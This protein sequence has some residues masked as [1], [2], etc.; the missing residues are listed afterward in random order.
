MTKQTKY[1]IKKLEKSIE[2]AKKFISKTENEDVIKDLK[3]GI[4]Q[5][6]I[7]IKKLGGVK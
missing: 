1:E 6:K 7:E 2:I 3:L 4:K 5:M